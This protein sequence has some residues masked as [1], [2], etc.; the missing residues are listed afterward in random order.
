MFGSYQRLILKSRC[1]FFPKTQRRFSH[2][3]QESFNTKWNIPITLAGCV[4][5]TLVV[6]YL[7]QQSVNA[8][9]EKSQIQRLKSNSYNLDPYHDQKYPKFPEPVCIQSHLI[10][11][12]QY[13]LP[14]GL[15]LKQVQI[16]FRHGERAPL[17]VPVDTPIEW[18]CDNEDGN[19]TVT[20]FSLH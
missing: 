7:M 18:Y 10:L 6:G 2:H 17:W 11:Q 1:T 14:N 20:P 15:V 8:D 19:G 12:L 16:L 9:D 3:K 13:E 4:G 5:G